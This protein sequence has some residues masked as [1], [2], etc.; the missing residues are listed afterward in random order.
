MG[1]GSNPTPPATDK[2]DDLAPFCIGPKT[3]IISDN[4]KIHVLF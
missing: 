2:P 3:G 4:R 1:S